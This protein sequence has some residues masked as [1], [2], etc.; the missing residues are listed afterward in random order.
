MRMKFLTLPVLCLAWPSSASAQWQYTEWGMNPE[1]V[2][3][4]SNGEVA[5]APSDPQREWGGVDIAAEGTYR[6]GEYEFKSIFYFERNELVS[7]H[8]ELQSTDLAGDAIA[9]RHSLYGVYGEPFDETT[10]IMTIV[11]WHDTKKNNRVD[12]FAI[13][14]RSVELRYRPLKD[15]SAAGL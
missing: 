5:R 8:L 12:L 2:V 15:D 4:A 11:T 10:G 9:L 13:G 6:S 7:V 14:D 3:A 1:Q